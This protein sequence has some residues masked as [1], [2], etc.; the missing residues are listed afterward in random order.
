MEYHVAEELEEYLR[1]LFKEQITIGPELTETVKPD[2]MIVLLETM[3]FLGIAKVEVQ[4]DGTLDYS[5]LKGNA[6]I[7]IEE[8]IKRKESGKVFELLQLLDK[9]NEGAMK[10]SEVEIFVAET[11]LDEGKIDEVMDT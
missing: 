2:V 6:P 9:V 4:K 1:D 10:L 8:K 5:P 11:F 7:I 3:R